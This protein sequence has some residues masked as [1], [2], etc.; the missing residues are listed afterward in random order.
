MPT[1]LDAKRERQ[2]EHLKEI[3]NKRG[4]S[5]IRAKENQ[6]A[7]KERARSGE[8]KEASKPSMRDNTSAYS[9]GVNAP[10]RDRSDPRPAL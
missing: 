2:Y 4:S 10:T 1:G 9:R 6:T 7:H 3:Q 5:A 8:P